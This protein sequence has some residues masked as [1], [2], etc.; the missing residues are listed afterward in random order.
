[1]RI[2][3]TKTNRIKIAAIDLDNCTL[4]INS[5]NEDK[6]SRVWWN[7]ASSQSYKE[8][9]II[10]HRIRDLDLE[11]PKRFYK[12][13]KLLLPTFISVFKDQLN[14]KGLPCYSVSTPEDTHKC[15]HNKKP[16]KLNMAYGDSSELGCFEVTDEF[17]GFFGKGYATHILP[18]EKDILARERK[19][20]ED[21]F[22]VEPDAAYVKGSADEYE[23]SHKNYQLL[24]LIWAQYNKHREITPD[25]EIEFDVFDDVPKIL[26]NYRSIPLKLLPPG[27][28]INIYE[29]N[30]SFQRLRFLYALSKI[31]IKEAKDESKEELMHESKD[32]LLTE[33]PEAKFSE[34]SDVTLFGSKAIKY[35]LN[36]VNEILAVFGK[37]YIYL[38]LKDS[39]GNVN[40]EKRRDHFAEFL[41]NTHKNGEITNL[42][43]D[44]T[45]QTF[46]KKG[47]Q[48][49]NPLSSQK[50]YDLLHPIKLEAP[51]NIKEAV[52]RFIDFLKEEDIFCEFGQNLLF[53]IT[54]T[55]A[56]CEN[57]G[58]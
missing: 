6:I 11:I 14:K 52:K 40:F 16:L 53:L 57:S 17:I 47:P 54:D 10:T 38:K 49:I 8:A 2:S 4:H 50:Y 7:F 20:T 24:Q 1:M 12:Q 9:V 58:K 46:K 15:E 55:S 35:N 43:E 27:V 28:K 3:P 23:N 30:A 41:K 39:I 37:I 42:D 45:F 29:C 48:L 44:I 5:L 36:A 56:Y 22:R 31:D 26:G 18:Q 13:G 32:H 51:E 33:K 19:N 34:T 21:L 25:C